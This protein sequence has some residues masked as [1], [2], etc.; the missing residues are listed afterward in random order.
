MITTSNNKVNYQKQLDKIISEECASRVPSVIMHACCAPC[1]SYV[2]EY[3]AKYFNLTMFF[4]NPN[5]DNASEY[6]KRAAELKKLVKQ[7][8]LPREVKVIEEKYCSEEFYSQISGLEDEPER[9]R[10]CD[11]C[12]HLRLMKTAQLAK[13]LKADYFCTTLTI[14]PHKDAANINAIG[15]KL[16]QEYGIKFLPSDFKKREGFKRSTQ[17]C[18]IYGL[19][20]QDYCGCIFS[21]R[22]NRN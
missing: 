22:A 6:D 8:P 17:L 9:G 5:I 7:M 20:R 12:F 18:E 10:R 2:I 15:E 13:K 16:A 11:K 19:Y 1:S 4:Y 3:L 14:S 21:K